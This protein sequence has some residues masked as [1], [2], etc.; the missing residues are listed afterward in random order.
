MTKSKLLQEACKR[1][2]WHI[3]DL[4]QYD[5]VSHYLAHCSHRST[6]VRGLF[7]SDK[8]VGRQLCLEEGAREHITILGLE[9]VSKGS[10]SPIM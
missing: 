7:K 10:W 4:L 2:D 1:I 9:N 3:K 6:D 5:D 8:S